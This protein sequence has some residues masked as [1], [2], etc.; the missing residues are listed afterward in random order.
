METRWVRYKSHRLHSTACGG[1]RHSNKENS[2]VKVTRRDA[3]KFAGLAVSAAVGTT[4]APRLSRAAATTIVER[5][6]C[7]IGGGSAGTYTAVRLGDLGKSVMLVERAARLGGHAETFIDPATDVPIDIGVTYFENTPLVT[8]YLNRFGVQPAIA[9]FA[10]QLSSNIDFRSG[11][12]VTIS[13]PSQAAVGAAMAQYYQILATQYPYL[14]AGFQL[15]DPVP[16]ELA[17]PFSS[18]V[19]T[20]GLQAL[21]PTIF[22]FAQGAGNL[23]NNPALYVLKLFS[24]NVVGSVLSGGLLNIPQGTQQ[25]YSAAQAYLGNNVLLNAN[26]QSISR[27]DVIE[28]LVSTPQGTTLIRSS[29]L[30][31]AAPPTVQNL[32]P[33]DLDGLETSTFAQLLPKTYS[34]GVVTIRGLPTGLS[35]NNVAADTAYNLPPLPALYRLQATTPGLYIA[36]FGT[37]ATPADASIRANIT[38]S[39]KLLA[40]AGTYPAVELDG[41]DIFS[42]HAPFQ[43]GVTGAQIAGGYYKVLNSLQG[44]NNTFYNGAAFQTNDSSLI[45]QF[46]EG[47]LP[48]VVS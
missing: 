38:N 20:H 23:L 17:A 29:K 42:N 3:L 28:T 39:V 11:L 12:P 33:V 45:W 22:Q 1:T 15:P 31:W 30:V 46:T 14:S 36:L 26:L 34:T 19:Q 2:N 44:R 21:V 43:L 5:D 41:F 6:V 4:V 13:P 35:L 8:A 37:D 40:S 32:K 25:L 9:S 27:G 47:L 24:L 7:V 48:Q 16:A 10:T 18:F